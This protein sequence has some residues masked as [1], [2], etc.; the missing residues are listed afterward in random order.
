LFARSRAQWRVHN[1]RA[2]R[3]HR[4]QP[5]VRWPRASP[6]AAIC[7]LD[8]GDPPSTPTDPTSSPFSPFP[9]RRARERFVA[10]RRR[11]RSC[12][13][14]RDAS[15]PL[16]VVN[17]TDLSPVPD[18]LSAGAIVA[19]GHCFSP[20]ISLFLQIITSDRPRKSGRGKE[21][22]TRRRPASAHPSLPNP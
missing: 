20:T 14:G 3:V 10:E 19:H 16:Q 4:W 15:V 18:A 22:D 12:I 5:V 9:F 8:E 1:A 2:P 11:A 6:F 17:E 13:A 7:S 21:R